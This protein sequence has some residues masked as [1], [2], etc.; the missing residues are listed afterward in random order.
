MKGKWFNV[1][2]PVKPH[3]RGLVVL[4]GCRQHVAQGGVCWLGV[5]ARPLQAPQNLLALQGSPRD[6]AHLVRQHLPVLWRPLVPLRRGWNGQQN[7]PR[8]GT[9]CRGPGAAPGVWAGYA[10]G[11]EGCTSSRVMGRGWFM[12]GLGKPSVSGRCFCGSLLPQ[13]GSSPCV[14]S[15]AVG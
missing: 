5:P 13:G 11:E 9:K 15:R 4:R 1:I 12:L 7:T 8:R 3:I 6:S 10:G 2:T 14:E